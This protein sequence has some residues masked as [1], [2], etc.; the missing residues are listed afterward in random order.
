MR[1]VTSIHP[2][3]YPLT[4]PQGRNYTSYNAR[5]RIAIVALLL[6]ALV[7]GPAQV[8]ETEPAWALKFMDFA[9]AADFHRKPAAPILPTKTQRVFRT[10]IRE[11]AAKGPNFAGHYTIAEWGCGSG[12]MSSVVV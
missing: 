7:S 3:L 6:L 12:C 4:S 10:A 5:M 11:A 9:V 8:T 2:A 1:P